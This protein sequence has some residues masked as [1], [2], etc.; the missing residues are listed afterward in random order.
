MNRLRETHNWF[1]GADPD[2]PRRA[3][4]VEIEDL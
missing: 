4:E 3:V 1:A 2:G